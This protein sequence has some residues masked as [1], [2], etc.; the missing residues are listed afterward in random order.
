MM[1]ENMCLPHRLIQHTRFAL[2]AYLN[3][4]FG[5]TSLMLETLDEIPADN[6]NGW[7]ARENHG[8]R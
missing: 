5:G 6:I 2:R 4:A 3:S 8:L 7:Q 1:R